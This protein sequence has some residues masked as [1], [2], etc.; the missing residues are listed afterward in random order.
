MSRLLIVTGAPATGKSTLA[1]RL[2]ADY[3]LELWSK[4]QF[5]ESLFETLGSGDA[6]W[7]RRLSDASFALLF[8]CADRVLRR[9]STVL[10]E[11]NFRRGE[12]EAPLSRLCQ[13]RGCR[14]AQVLC[15]ADETVRA[16]R[17][18]QRSAEP[19]RHPGHADA[20]RA[21]RRSAQDDFLELP[22]LRLRYGGEAGGYPDLRA[23]LDQWWST[24]STSV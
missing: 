8:D 15:E 13:R 10:L 17:L 5:K 9:T 6:A 14:V 20:A 23:A 12:H 7:S 3:G 24:S 19:S 22:G 4:D 21:M 11:A 18:A 1:A 2:A 16:A